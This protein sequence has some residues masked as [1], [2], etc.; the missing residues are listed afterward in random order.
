MHEAMVRWGVMFGKIICKII[1]PT[2]PVHY[3]LIL[4]DPIAEPVESQVDGFGASLFDSLINN[5]SST[6]NVGLNRSRGLWVS[7][8]C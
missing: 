6:C 8:F 5:T 1:S 3:K 4:F 2:S 7:K